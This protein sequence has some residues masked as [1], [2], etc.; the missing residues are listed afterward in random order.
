MASYKFIHTQENA[1]TSYN[2]TQERL[3]KERKKKEKKKKVVPKGN[4]N[5]TSKK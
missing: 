4:S 1:L 2:S 5:V 3:E